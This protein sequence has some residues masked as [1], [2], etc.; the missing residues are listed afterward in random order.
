MQTE[1]DIGQYDIREVDENFPRGARRSEN[2]NNKLPP[3]GS[4]K[5]PEMD[6]AK[7]NMVLMFSPLC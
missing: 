5:S 3:L 1:S 2:N 4:I 7:R 6:Y